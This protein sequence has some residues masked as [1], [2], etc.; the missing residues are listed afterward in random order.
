VVERL[1][2]DHQRQRADH[3]ARLYALLFLELWFREFVD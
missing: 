1:I 3:S 2:D